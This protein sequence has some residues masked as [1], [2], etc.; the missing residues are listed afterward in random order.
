M[1]TEL[2]TVLVLVPMGTTCSG[3]VFCN[4]SLYKPSPHS[5]QNFHCKMWGFHYKIGD[6]H[7]KTGDAF[8]PKSSPYRPK[9]ECLA[10]REL[11]DKQLV[12]H[13]LRGSLDV[14]QHF[15]KL[16]DDGSSTSCL[17]QAVKPRRCP[18]CLG[19]H[20]LPSPGWARSPSKAFVGIYRGWSSRAAIPGETSRGSSSHRKWI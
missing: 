17:L 16:Q 1:S 7:S 14:L 8:P 20:R 15:W 10:K 19:L 13:K 18:A 4:M 6:F 9:E 5:L 3:H 11:I 12:V 2:S